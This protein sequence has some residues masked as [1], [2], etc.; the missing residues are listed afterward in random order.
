MDQLK[1]FTFYD[2]YWKLIKSASDEATRALFKHKDFRE[3]WERDYATQELLYLAEL[4]PKD[5]PLY[6]A[7]KEMAIYRNSID[8]AVGTII[9]VD[10]N[11]AKA[12]RA[13]REELEQ[14]RTALQ[15]IMG[16]YYKA[17]LGFET[18]DEYFDYVEY[19]KVKATRQKRVTA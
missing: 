2:L 10:E 19:M 5:K 12:D 7:S 14:K 8:F 4:L 3:A 15:G 16:K 6:Y 1:Q 13:F 9:D 18:L 17:R 11:V